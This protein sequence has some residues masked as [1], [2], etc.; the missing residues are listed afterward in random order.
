LLLPAPETVSNVVEAA[1]AS[2]ITIPRTSTVDSASP[3][4]IKHSNTLQV[5]A[6]PA[7]SVGSSASHRPPPS[8]TTVTTATLII[9]WDPEISLLMRSLEAAILAVAQ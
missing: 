3:P 4:Q 5:V 9:M 7:P 8:P 6:S 1:P 2:T